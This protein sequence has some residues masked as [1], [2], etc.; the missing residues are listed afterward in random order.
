MWRPVLRRDEL[1][2]MIAVETDDCILWPYAKHDDDGYGSVYVGNRGARLV[3]QVAAEQVHGPC[4]EGME[5]AHSCR[6]K[7]CFNPRHLSYKTRQGNV[8]DKRRDGTN[9]TGSRNP[10]AKLSQGD[11]DAIRASTDSYST[12]AQRYGVTKTHIYY[13]RSNR[14]WKEEAA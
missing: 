1:T 6:N 5:V 4:P 3:H 14:T 7:N 10:Q 11:V 12:L 9:T 2:A 8:D 13:I